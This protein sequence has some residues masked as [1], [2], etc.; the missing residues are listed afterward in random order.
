MFE[1]GK[2]DVE[3]RKFRAES[4]KKGLDLRRECAGKTALKMPW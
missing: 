1:A 4:C 3:G 2:I